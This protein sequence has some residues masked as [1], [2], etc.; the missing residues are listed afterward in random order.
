MDDSKVLVLAHTNLLLKW[1]KMDNA[2]HVREVREKK[3]ITKGPWFQKFEAEAGRVNFPF[4]AT[5]SILALYAWSQIYTLLLEDGFFAKDFDI[6]EFLK[7][8]VINIKAMISHVEMLNYV[9]NI[10]FNRIPDIMDKQ[11]LLKPL[12]EEEM[13]LDP[14]SISD[15]IVDMK[16][17][18]GDSNIEI[19]NELLSS[20]NIIHQEMLNKFKKNWLFVYNMDGVRNL[21]M[22]LNNMKEYIRSVRSS[23]MLL[24]KIL[25]SNY[26]VVRPMTEIFDFFTAGRNAVY[27]CSQLL[28]VKLN[29]LPKYK[30]L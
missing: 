30:V 9:Q 23:D 21:E 14:F 8:E 16:I 4:M 10:N 18:N 2:L 15:E 13:V 26:E 17:Y 28:E 20:P 6:T 5:Y 12:S 19:P 22:F 11:L 7:Q 25:E 29:G 1:C 24:T 3:E 27:S